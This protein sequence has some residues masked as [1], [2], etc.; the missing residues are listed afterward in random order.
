MFGLMIVTKNKLDKI[1]KQAKEQAI[2]ELVQLLLKKDK[3]YLEPVVI[4]GGG[5]RISDCVFFAVGEGKSALTINSAP[6]V[7]ED[8]CAEIV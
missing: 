3:I 8:C 6:T 4:N 2:S 5:A 7:I 1:K